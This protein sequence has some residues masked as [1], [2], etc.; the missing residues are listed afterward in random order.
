M[1]DREINGIMTPEKLKE[2]EPKIACLRRMGVHNLFAAIAGVDREVF[3]AAG[4]AVAG[5]K[6]GPARSYIEMKLQLN[7][8]G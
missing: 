6:S 1:S 4:W 2:W 8:G 7:R 5:V 3:E